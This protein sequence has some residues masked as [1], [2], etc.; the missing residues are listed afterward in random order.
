MSNDAVKGEI[1]EP[2]K[3]EKNELS[4]LDLVAVLFKFWW[5]I[6][7]TTFIAAISIFLYC[8]I[9]TKL[10]PEKTYMP[11]TYQSKAEMLINNS[12]SGGSASALLSSAGLSSLLGS[13]KNGPT[14][15]SLAQYFV[16]SNKTLDLIIDKFYREKIER[17]HKKEVEAAIAAGK[18]YDEDWKFPATKT[19]QMLK[20]KIKTSYNTSTGVFTI[21]VSDKNPQFACD[22][23]NYTVELLEKRFTEIGLDKNEVTLRNL[24]ANIE[25]TYQ[26][27]LDLQ[28]K[29][30]QYNYSASDGYEYDS[31]IA[32]D[33]SMMQVELDVQKKLYSNLKNQ[34]ETL[35]ISM[36][37]DSP[38]FQILEYAEIPDLKSGPDR[39]KK[40]IKVTAIAF[41][42]S[43]IAAYGIDFI[44]KLK[45]N[46]EVQ[47][48]L[49]PKKKGKK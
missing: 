16:G 18:K 43:L 23:I 17:R 8:F 24:E 25:K 20:R 26:N 41:I 9:A 38:V 22:L 11:N 30:Q 3:I 19:R 34:Y 13:A 2:V 36:A 48:K 46:P 35:K 47:A 7:G 5:L 10:P 29:T 39:K 49:H 31:S 27:I 37:N 21:S 33:T 28:T 12:G 44:S 4:I 15:S 32:F 42:A 14:A 6:I 40:C 1:I 45:K